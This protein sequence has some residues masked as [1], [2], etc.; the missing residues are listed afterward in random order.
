M[1]PWAM[2]MF[3]TGLFLLA[4]LLIWDFNFLGARS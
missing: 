2:L 3:A 4:L 1:I